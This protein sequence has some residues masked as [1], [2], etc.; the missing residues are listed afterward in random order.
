MQRSLLV[1]VFVGLFLLGCSNSKTSSDKFCLDPPIEASM[2]FSSID[3][4]FSKML[5]S[6]NRSERYS[7]THYLKATLGDETVKHYGNL[8]YKVSHPPGRLKIYE[9][10]G[11]FGS[12]ANASLLAYYLQVEEEVKVKAQII[13][14]LGHIGTDAA[15][16]T[17]LIEHLSKSYPTHYKAQQSRGGSISARSG[18]ITWIVRDDSMSPEQFVAISNESIKK[19]QSHGQ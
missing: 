19:I 10:M 13:C 2:K 6:D 4:A 5:N 1:S 9:S 14:S 8:L 17:R 12:N 11:Y 15:E 7:A 18:D 16:F 3:E